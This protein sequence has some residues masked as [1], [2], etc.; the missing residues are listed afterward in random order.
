MGGTGSFLGR[1]GK[2]RLYSPVCPAPTDFSE[3]SLKGKLVG[4][5]ELWGSLSLKNFLLCHGELPNILSSG[6]SLDPNQ[7][8][9]GSE[10]VLH[11]LAY[12]FPKQ[13]RNKT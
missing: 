8:A 1:E 2:R 4:F 7:E 13:G 3:S 12:V 5:A 10:L 11:L 6:I 9:A